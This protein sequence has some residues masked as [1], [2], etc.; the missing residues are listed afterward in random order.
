MPANT[1]KVNELRRR[2]FCRRF[3]LIPPTGVMRGRQKNIPTTELCNSSW[4]TERRF[5]SLLSSPNATTIRSS[6]VYNI[7]NEEQCKHHPAYDLRPFDAF[8]EILLIIK[9]FKQ[10]AFI[11]EHGDRVG[12]D[13]PEHEHGKKRLSHRY[14]Q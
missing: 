12:V 10:M 14:L 4:H 13:A 8:Q 9:E 5:S 3:L 6:H 11:E 7:K 1:S 2:Y